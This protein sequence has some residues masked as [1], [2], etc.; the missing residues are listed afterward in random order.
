MVALLPTLGALNPSSLS[1]IDTNI[2][3]EPENTHPP[4]L[5]LLPASAEEEDAPNVALRLCMARMRV[6]IDLLMTNLVTCAIIACCLLR[7]CAMR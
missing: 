6:S 1:P 5:L 7:V 3:T 4:L 2:F